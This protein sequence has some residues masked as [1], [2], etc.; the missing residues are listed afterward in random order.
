VDT[1]TLGTGAVNLSLS[2][3]ADIIIVGNGDIDSADTIAGG[4]GDD[5]IRVEAGGATYV[6][7]DFA[8]VTTVEQIEASTNNGTLSATLSTNAA[9]AGIDSID[10]GTGA[11]TINI[12]GYTISTTLTGGAGNDTITGGGAADTI[13]AGT[14]DDR[15]VITDADP[16]T[17]VADRVV[18]TASATNGSDT[19]VGYESGTD[20]IVLVDADTT[21]GLDAGNV[22][23]V[24][25]N[26]NPA[27]VVGATFSLVADIDTD[28][29]SVVELLGTND[30][31]GDLSAATDGTELF[32]LLGATGS[33]ATSLT[34]DAA[35]D[36]LFLV[37]YDNG[38]AY[39]YHVQDSA[40][41]TVVAAEVLLVAT[42]TGMAVG[43]FADNDFIVA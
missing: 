3:A 26:A 34:M 27:L 37:A 36:N 11:D 31:N 4:N 18:M 6:D 13:T 21:N 10:G 40:G 23:L 14:G 33:A 16:D 12:T 30:S 22:T 9:T 2:D 32:K 17:N 25:I 5:V 20:K 24:T 39:I 38:N 42:V 35:D 43:G 19:I 41:A 28:V 1:I 15:I 29:D 8:N 7:A